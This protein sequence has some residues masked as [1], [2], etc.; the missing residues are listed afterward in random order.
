MGVVYRARHTALGKLVALKVISTSLQFDPHA[1]DR[2]LR[3]MQAIGRLEPHPN[4]LNAYDAGHE[5]GVQYLATEYIEGV[6]LGTLVKRIGPLSV[7]EACKIISQ[8][9]QALEHLRGH[10]LVHRDIKPSNLM[11]TRDGT[12]K[13]VDMGLALLRDEQTETLTSFGETM[14]SIDYMAPEQWA[15]S[16]SVDWRSD[17]YSL[18]CTFYCLLAGHPPY[19]MKRGGSLGRLKAHLEAKF[20]DIRA[21]RSDV[22]DQA[23]EMILQMVSKDPKTRL[24]DL[25]G[26]SRRLEII[27]CGDLQGLVARGF[28]TAAPRPESAI[29]QSAMTIDSVTAEDASSRA[30][31]PSSGALDGGDPQ[32]ETRTLQ[33]SV[34][35]TSQPDEKY[36][37][38]GPQRGGQKP[39][40]IGT[41]VAG[42][43]AVTAIAYG[44]FRSEPDPASDHAS[45]HVLPSPPEGSPAAVLLPIASFGE[46]I[47]IATQQGTIH[48]MEFLAS[49]NHLVTVS[50]QGLLTI[51]DLDTP[52]RPLHSVS[53]SDDSADS[54]VY[55]AEAG[56]L[57]IA[58]ADGWLRLHTAK[59]GT[60]LRDVAQASAGLTGV[61]QIPGE[62]AY[63][64]SDWNGDIRQIDTSAA[65]ATNTLIAHRAEAVYDVAC[66]ADGRWL[67]WCGREPLVTLMNRDNQQRQDLSGHQDWVV[68]VA[69][70]PDASRLASAGHDGQ[71]RIWEVPSGQLQTSISCVV[72]QTLCFFPNS[73]FLAI[74]GRASHVLVWDLQAD[75]QL[76]TLP[77]NNHIDSLA[78]SEDGQWLAAG[79]NSGTVT[80]WRITFELTPEDGR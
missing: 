20:P 70:A 51:F 19:K 79:D 15:D 22:P 13:V 31:P 65:P 21:L 56:T 46:P 43:L 18:G 69:F 72:P 77:V 74:G 62:P 12:V 40:L 45:N 33:Y 41:A 6:Q 78:V 1:M 14:G 71:V 64:T 10:H 8:A 66:S 47:T 29:S 37:N 80:V 44:P 57:M 48:D 5:D 35:P 34:L 11:L 26:L 39:W 9:A 27:A 53:V 28:D 16:H 54:I 2:F 67:A 55:D 4:V 42:I 32:A 52:N 68:D 36:E 61:E 50:K 76:L 58:S 38:G 60:A 25:P 73:R 17:I 3:E 30:E 23:A 49:D 59:D 63:L 24:T 75:R 7:S